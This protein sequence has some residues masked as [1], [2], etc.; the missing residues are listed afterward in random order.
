MQMLAM[1]LARSA[2]ASGG[3]EADVSARS[4][5]AR[6]TSAAPGFVRM[7]TTQH[8]SASARASRSW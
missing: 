2:G 3:R 4:T 6:M 7:S 5:R 1:K 8:C